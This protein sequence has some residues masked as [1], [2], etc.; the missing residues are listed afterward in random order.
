MSRCDQPGYTPNAIR[1]NIKKMLHEYNPNQH[2]VDF[3]ERDIPPRDRDLRTH[4]VLTDLMKLRNRLDQD[5]Q[6]DVASV[7][8]DGT[9]LDP[10]RNCAE[11]FSQRDVHYNRINRKMYAVYAASAYIVHDRNFSSY[12]RPALRHLPDTTAFKLALIRKR[13]QPSPDEKAPYTTVQRPATTHTQP[14]FASSRPTYADVLR[15]PLQPRPEWM[16]NTPPLMSNDEAD[17]VWRQGVD[18]LLGQ[19]SPTINELKNQIHQL[20]QQVQQREAIE[21]QTQTHPHGNTFASRISRQGFRQPTADEKQKEAED[22]SEADDTLFSTVRQSDGRKNKFTS[23]TALPTPKNDQF[24]PTRDGMDQ[25][26]SNKKPLPNPRAPSGRKLNSRVPIASRTSG[27]SPSSLGSSSQGQQ[28]DNMIPPPRTDHQIEGQSRK[29]TRTVTSPTT[30]K[31]LKN[32]DFGG[33]TFWNR[34]ALTK[35]TTS[36]EPKALVMSASPSAPYDLIVDTGASHVLFQKKHMG[37]LTNIQL[38]NPNLKPFAILKAANGQILKAIGRGVFRIKKIS[39]LAYIFKDEDLVH[40]LLGIAPFAD[41]GCRAVFTATAF[42]LYHHKTLLLTGKR[43]SA[44]L[45]HITLPG[46]KFR[47]VPPRQM[48][49]S[50]SI[51]K[52]VLLLHDNTRTAERYVQFIHACLGSP[53]P[54]TFLRAVERGFFAGELQFSRLTPKMV[55]KH[56]PDSEATARGHLNKTPTSRPH[57]LSQSVSA[58]RRHHA[59]SQNKVRTSSLQTKVLTNL[60]LTHDKFEAAI[61]MQPEAAR[62]PVEQER[63]REEPTSAPFDPTT[64]TRSKTLHL[65]YTGRMASRGSNGTLYFLYP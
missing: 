21:R 25:S 11:E 1:D 45:W 33:G 30:T 37:L 16:K 60:N 58:R 38:S 50:T 47:P 12:C 19:R 29:H 52:P 20:Q 39:V 28:T 55:R 24:S 6:L 63:T 13:L 42:T 17:R 61:T 5:F 41:C 46:V 34:P 51:A 14:T 7:A 10:S 56:M 9:P 8:A 2:V 43:H 57:S 40:N 31:R 48:A 62:Y 36:Q 32:N 49:A 26:A 65:D 59:K 35:R 4:N 3:Q 64:V 23:S 15:S 54:T 18:T 22:Q 53:P 27:L 44:N